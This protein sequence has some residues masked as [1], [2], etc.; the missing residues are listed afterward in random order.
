MY[1]NQKS[2]GL[3]LPELLHICL[4]LNRL[5][6]KCHQVSSKTQHKQTIAENSAQW[7]PPL[8]GFLKVNFDSAFDGNITVSCVVI[9]DIHGI[10]KHTWTGCSI[11]SSAFEAEA[12]PAIQAMKLAAD[13]QLCKSVFED[14]AVNVILALNGM[15]FCVEWQGKPAILQGRSFFFFGVKIASGLLPMFTVLFTT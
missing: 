6:Q 3:D 12:L 4:M 2:R 5:T 1:R 15:D 14:D 8:L 9:R 11:A 13:S 10:V 7:S